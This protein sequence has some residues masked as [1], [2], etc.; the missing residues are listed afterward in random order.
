[1]SGVEL[2]WLMIAAMFMS[3]GFTILVILLFEIPRKKHKKKYHKSLISILDK[4]IDKWKQMEDGVIPMGDILVLKMQIDHFC[5]VIQCDTILYLP[6]QKHSM[7]YFKICYT[8]KKAEAEVENAR[9]QVFG[10]RKT[11]K[12]IGGTTCK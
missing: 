8:I 12:P 11:E 3:V 6:Y 9:R 2:A 7:D 10:T 4:Y 1:M 5:Q